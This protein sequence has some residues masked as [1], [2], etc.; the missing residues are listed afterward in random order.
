MKY[1]NYR[2]I[3]EYGRDTILTN[4]TEGGEDPYGDATLVENTATIKAIRKQYKGGFERDASGAIPTGDAVFF[5]KDDEDICEGGTQKASKLTLDDQDY[6]VK[7]IDDQ[8]TGMIAI[9]VERERP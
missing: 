2:Y 1:Q 9:L 7:T 5:V 3:E 4:Y 6:V 8:G